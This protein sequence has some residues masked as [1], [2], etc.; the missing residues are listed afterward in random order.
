MILSSFLLFLFDYFLS[1]GFLSYAI[2]CGSEYSSYIDSFRKKICGN[3]LYV[4]TNFDLIER[5]EISKTVHIEDQ[6]CFPRY[7][8]NNAGY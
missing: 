7:D 3:K 5:E 6:P 8:F 4:L 1:K 2:E